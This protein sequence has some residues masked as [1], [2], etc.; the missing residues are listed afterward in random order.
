M[1]NDHLNFP[2]VK[3]RQVNSEQMQA[4]LGAFLLCTTSI[5]LQTINLENDS[6]SQQDTLASEPKWMF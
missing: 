5:H 2:D 6:R 1:S 3:Q 4:Y